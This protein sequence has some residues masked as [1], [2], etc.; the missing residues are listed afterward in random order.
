M[1]VESI[2]K[3]WG[4]GEKGFVPEKGFAHLNPFRS[5][6]RA[7]RALLGFLNGSDGSD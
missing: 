5:A 1:D 2:C 6:A 3:K 4:L 7:A